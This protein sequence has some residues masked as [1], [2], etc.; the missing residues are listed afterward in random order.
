MLLGLSF[1]SKLNWGSYIVSIAKTTSKKIGTLIRSKK[2]LSLE[3]ALYL[4]KSTIWLSM[5]YYCHVWL[6][7]PSCYLDRLKKLQ[8]QIYQTVGP[9]FAAPLKP[10]A[11]GRNVANLPLFYS[12]YFGICSCKL[13]QL[14]PP[15]HLAGSISR[16][17]KDVYVN[18]FFPHTA[19]L[20]NPMPME[21]FPLTFNLNS[22]NP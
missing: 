13:A 4:Y 9:S 15:I 6:S 8:K 14:F 19:G 22:F 7:A 12:Y 18:S 20:S 11:H 3:V 2:F 5:E 1:S 17:Y 21:C 16:F 10:F